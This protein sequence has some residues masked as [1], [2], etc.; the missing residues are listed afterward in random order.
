MNILIPQ[1]LLFGGAFPACLA[2]T[3]LQLRSLAGE[4]GQTPPFSPDELRRLTGKS[5]PT[6]YRHL[7]R[8]KAAGLLDW[9][10][11]AGGLQVIF[12]ELDVV[13]QP[14]VIDGQ[15]PAGLETV[16]FSILRDSQ[17]CNCAS[18]NTLTDSL[19]NLT[20]EEASFSKSKSR[21]KTRKALP[22]DKASEMNAEAKAQTA[23]READAAGIYR[24]LARLTPN[25]A[26]RDLLL[27]QVHDLPRWRETL[28]HWLAHRWNPRNLPGMLDLYRRGGASTCRYCPK[29][30][31]PKTAEAFQQLR[32]QYPAEPASP[33]REPASPLQEPASPLREP[34]NLLRESPPPACSEA[35]G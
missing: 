35:T 29:T 28:E 24:L 7:R 19:I 32:A 18:L 22:P 16:E 8:L 31:P 9:R 11:L 34:A 4:T 14:A 33:L 6:L 13:Q 12:G 2:H 21:S 5:L 3:W 23:L 15:E 10:C 17:N 30:E 1:N 20:R 27:G 26:Q 25:P